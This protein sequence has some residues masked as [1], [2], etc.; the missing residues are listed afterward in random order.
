MQMW[1]YFVYALLPFPL[2]YLLLISL[3]L[4]GVISRPINSTATKVAKWLVNGKF[5]GGFS[6]YQVAVVISSLLFAES[7][8]STASAAQRYE[9]SRN[10]INEDKYR[11]LKW[12]SERNFWIAFMSLALWIV[13]N[14]VAELIKENEELQRRRD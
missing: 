10:S 8:F 1:G 13:F 12:R 11:G 9:D 7:A 5:I 4:P 2:F 14:R 3:P 6:P